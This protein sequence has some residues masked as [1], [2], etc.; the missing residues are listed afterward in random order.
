VEQ[1]LYL[2]FYAE[3]AREPFDSP[4]VTQML[5]RL[6]PQ[7]SAFRG[8]TYARRRAW[9]SA[10]AD[11]RAAVEDHGDVDPQLVYICGA[12]LFAARKYDRAIANL[13]RA[14]ALAPAD[15]DGGVASQARKL[16]LKLTTALLRGARTSC[17]D[18]PR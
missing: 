9:A 16:A 7:A 12:G 6:G 13:T 11:L 8:F 18:K 17:V 15:E 10:A 1:E 14:A 5:A 4:I 2:S 3:L